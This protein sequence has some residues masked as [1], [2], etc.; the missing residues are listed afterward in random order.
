L[1]EYYPEIIMN[2]PAKRAAVYQVK[3]LSIATFS[4]LQSGRTVVSSGKATSPWIAMKCRP[5]SRA[6][7]K[8]V[9]ASPIIKT[10]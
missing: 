8:S 9:K 3:C 1:Q 10:Q 5:V 4:P 2:K 6:A 7:L